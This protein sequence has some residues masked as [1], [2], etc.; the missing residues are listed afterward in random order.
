MLSFCPS[1]LFARLGGSSLRFVVIFWSSLSSS[2][3]WP[4]KLLLLSGPQLGSVV[5]RP[6][7]QEDGTT[8]D[9][10]A[11]LARLPSSCCVSTRPG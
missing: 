11:G 5:E 4:T 10:S 9:S 1:S 2:L 8:D 6:V 7:C 3:W